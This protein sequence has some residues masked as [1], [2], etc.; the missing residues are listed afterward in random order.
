[1]ARAYKSHLYSQIPMSWLVQNGRENSRAMVVT[2]E[3]VTC[4]SADNHEGWKHTAQHSRQRTAGP[5]HGTHLFTSVSP[6]HPSPLNHIKSTEPQYQR[7]FTKTNVSLLRQTL[8]YHGTLTWYAALI[9]RP[10]DSFTCHVLITATVRYSTKFNRHT[11]LYLVAE[12]KSYY[13]DHAQSTSMIK[14]VMLSTTRCLYFSNRMSVSRSIR[15]PLT[16]SNC[17]APNHK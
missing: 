9:S 12:H 17:P 8:K 2:V 5:I 3:Q 13:Q 1:M 7:Y 4:A 15:T 11:L 6:R 14:N 16:H 10:L